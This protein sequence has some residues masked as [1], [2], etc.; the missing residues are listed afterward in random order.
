MSGLPAA[1]LNEIFQNLAGY[2]PARKWK[3]HFVKTLHLERWQ[4]SFSEG[5][6]YGCSFPAEASLQRNL[7][8]ENPSHTYLHLHAESNFITN[9]IWMLT[10]AL[11]FQPAL[12]QFEVKTGKNCS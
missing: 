11:R 8:F 10:T 7:K 9:P 3:Y 4:L 2:F 12:L 1:K 6:M 5:Q